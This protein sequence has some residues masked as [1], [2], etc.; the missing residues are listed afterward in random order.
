G[1]AAR[2][3][4]PGAGGG[5]SAATAGGGGRAGQP[6]AA[7]ASGGGW[8]STDG[9]TAFKPVFDDYTQSIGAI[10]VDPSKRDTVWVGT[11]ESW[12][13]NS[14]SVGTGVYKTTPGG[15]GWAL[16]GLQNSQ[17]HARRAIASKQSHTVYRRAP[18]HL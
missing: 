13:R 12:M 7:P 15:G 6:G 14:V 10:A 17:P 1:L 4:A 9:G 3:L 16:L 5:R 11:G 8:K 18:G 2:C